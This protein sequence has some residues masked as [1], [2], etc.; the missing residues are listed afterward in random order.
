MTDDGKP[1]LIGQV[2]DKLLRS[3]QDWAKEGRLL[4]GRPDFGHV[5]RLPPGQ[6]EVKNWPVLDLGV[7]P[8]VQPEQWR[9]QIGGGG[10]PLSGRLPNSWQPQ[11][12]FARTHCVT[13]WSR[14]DNQWGYFRPPSSISSAEDRGAPHRLHL[15]LHHQCETRS[16]RAQRADRA[17]LGRNRFR[18]G[19]VDQSA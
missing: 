9:L 10:N 2:K 12:D 4:T 19:T 1:E 11:E 13:Q 15:W 6:K 14:Y 17:F 7:Q 16:V 8:D 5:N 3:K 18:A